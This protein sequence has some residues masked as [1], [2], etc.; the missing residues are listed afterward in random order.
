MSRRNGTHFLD[1]YSFVYNISYVGVDLI[2]CLA[3]FALA[4]KAMG[5][6][7]QGADL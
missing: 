2:L 5:K 1:L 7:Y 4:S 6:Y 3:I